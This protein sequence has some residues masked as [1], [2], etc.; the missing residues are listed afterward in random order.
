MMFFLYCVVVGCIINGCDL[1]DVFNDVVYKI[2]D[3]IFMYLEFE[4]CG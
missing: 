2:V 1:F 4:S 3:F